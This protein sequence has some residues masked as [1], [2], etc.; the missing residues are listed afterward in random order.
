M[1][2]SETQVPSE[3]EIVP[4]L[5]LNSL[6]S[7]HSELMKERRQGEP[8]DAFWNQVVEFLRCGQAGGA[9]MDDDGER[10]TAQSLL[11]YWENQLFHEGKE[12]PEAVLA[13]FDPQKFPPIPDY[14]CPYVGLGAFQA[15]N[16]DSFYGRSQLIDDLL[17]H[18]M[19]NQLIAV[20]GP[21]GSG[22]SSVILAGLLPRLQDGALPGSQN[23]RYYDPIVPGSMP[24]MRLARLLQ[25][26]DV[27][28]EEWLAAEAKNLN[29]NHDHLT[30]L[31]NQSGA[32]P[33][34]IVIDQ[35]EETFTLCQ[36]ED[37]REAFINNLLNLIRARGQRH[38]LIITMRADYESYLEKV[39][40]FKSMFEQ[41]EVRVSAMHAG[42]LR[43]AIEK[44][45]Q[46]IGL[47]FEEGLVDQLIREILG[48]PAALPLLQF[49]LL[50]LWD[51]RERN[52]ITW[53]SYRQ[54]GGVMEALAN[55]ADTLYKNLLPEEQVTARR[56]LLQIVR[57]SEGLEVT[58]NRVR[59]EMLYLSGEA[60][61]R[62]DRVLDKL[63]QSRLVHLT[64]GETS[65]DDQVEVAHEALVRN[66]PRLVEW[67]EDERV[68]LR[69]RH[70][71]TAQAEQWDARGRSKNDSVLLRGWLLDE[72]KNF[73]G[74]SGLET[75]FVNVSEAA[76][77]KAEKDEE[78]R[79]QRELA[80]AQEL[81]RR[82][83][84]I[85]EEQK[86]KAKAEAEAKEHAEELADEQKVR[87]DAQALAREQ[88]EDLA[89]AQKRFIVALII[90][91]IITVGGLI[92]AAN[93]RQQQTE[94]ERDALAADATIRAQALAEGTLM[95]EQNTKQ[96]ELATIAVE[97]ATTDVQIAISQAEA[98]TRSLLEATEAAEDVA[99]KAT[100]DQAIIVV[101]ATQ[102]A[103]TLATAVALTPTSARP[104]ATLEP[105]ALVAQYEQAAQLESFIREKDSMPMLFVT[106]SVF[107][108]GQGKDDPD[109]GTNV[110]M[111]HSVTVGDFYIDQYEVSVRQFASFLNDIGGYENMCAGFDCTLTGFET[112]FTYLLNN[113]GVMEPKAGS[114]NFP[115]NW[116][117]WYGADEYCRWVGGQLP[118]E[119]EW[120]YAARAIDGRIYPWGD[121]SP[122]SRLAIYGGTRNENSFFA[123]FEPADALPAGV[124]PFGAYNM[125]GSVREWTQGAADGQQRILRGGSWVKD[126]DEIYT[127]SRE[128]MVAVLS[129][130]AVRS[131]AYWDVGFRCAMPAS[132]KPKS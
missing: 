132:A 69:R 123:A 7:A 118:T 113:F 8:T 53:E 68:T 24:L 81:A 100:E 15:E 77:R 91:F 30:E 102:T 74:L 22:K 29:R 28:A 66:W 59:R 45:A 12:P 13:E 47:K 128:S 35:F 26:D 10:I 131:L 78:D 90:L 126:A 23:W 116:V 44:P 43:E 84:L 72:A 14:L 103:Q 9:Y 73:A 25:P 38:L 63:V 112:Q 92:I 95:A 31:V 62:I 67:L 1:S 97:Q 114:E 27:N 39:S 109:G 124:S 60:H 55:T 75:A 80:Q 125:A 11:D 119:A 2:N 57:P 129:D 70:R 33:A 5:S 89:N 104:T 64:K 130:N 54:L 79:R 65:V 110:E 17:R 46:D 105:A 32:N 127:Y 99:A 101:E 50:Q 56:I 94:L 18:V 76:V 82:A 115:I 120:E 19:V 106:G 3:E 108:M 40:L 49:A 111:V 107:S 20:V 122:N 96:A 37:E 36:N 21:S 71:L 48:E 6:R 58:R 121:A 52:R 88:A 42:E 51:N 83:E 4:F 117:S 34:V 61:D 41:G 16:R 87:A 86:A 85:A 98:A 93:T